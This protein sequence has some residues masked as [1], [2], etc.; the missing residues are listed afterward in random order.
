MATNSS[1]VSAAAAPMVP[2]KKSCQPKALYAATDDSR[3][4]PAPDG[5][6]SSRR[7]RRSNF[8]K[9]HPGPRTPP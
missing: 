8:P 4:S 1:P 9:F 2:M 6:P 3:T 5:R 7:M